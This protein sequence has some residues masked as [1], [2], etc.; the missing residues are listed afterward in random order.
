M[1][2]ELTPRTFFPWNARAAAPAAADPDPPRVTQ[3]QEGADE[4]GSAPPDGG[5]I[6]ATA[7]LGLIESLTDESWRSALAHEFAKPYFDRL[8]TQ[9]AS[10]RAQKPLHGQP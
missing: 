9:V 5:G 7:A 8:A 1:G 4:A 3:T 6:A 10:Q 2:E